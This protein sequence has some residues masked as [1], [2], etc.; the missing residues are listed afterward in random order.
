[1]AT[2]TVK[3]FN[4]RKG[5]GFITPDEGEQDVFVHISAVQQAGLRSLKEG[6]KIS[7]ELMEEKGKTVAGNLKL[8]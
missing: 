8:D 5:Y 2:G 3:W 4:N 6:A 1:M 7:Y